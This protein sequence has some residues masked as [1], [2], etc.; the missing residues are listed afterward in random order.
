MAK[1]RHQLAST[2]F[3]VNRIQAIQGEPITPTIK[4]EGVLVIYFLTDKSTADIQLNEQLS[5]PMNKRVD[6]KR[7]IP[8]IRWKRKD[9]KKVRRRNVARVDWYTT[10][11]LCKRISAHIIL[12]CLATIRPTNNIQCETFVKLDKLTIF[13]P[14]LFFSYPLSKEKASHVN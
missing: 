10:R 3:A 12:P 6:E 11:D 9:E 4:N 14:S 8:T 1:L 13:L 7:A 2:K 5:T